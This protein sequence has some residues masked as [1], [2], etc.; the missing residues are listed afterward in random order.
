MGEGLSDVEVLYTRQLLHLLKQDSA[1]IALL[2]AAST[3]QLN[4]WCLAAGFVRNLVWDS[5]HS[6]TVPTA[7][8]DIDLIYFDPNDVSEQ[9]EYNYEQQL[10]LLAPVNWSVK[11]QARMHTRNADKPYL[12]SLDAMRYWPE[13]ETAVGARL[14][15]DRIEIIAPFGL[16]SLFA[17]EITLNPERPKPEVLQARIADKKWLIQWPQLKLILA[18]DH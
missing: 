4:D 13:V 1:R 7:L 18:V 15:S 10:R 2:N 16:A 5:L 6:F 14:V 12:N 9:Q 8:S 11:N 17:G 3:L